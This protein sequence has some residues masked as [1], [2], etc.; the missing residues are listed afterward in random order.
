MSVGS[1]KSKRPNG[2][3]VMGS[4]ITGE[5]DAAEAGERSDSDVFCFRAN[6]ITSTHQEEPGH[7]FEDDSDVEMCLDFDPINVHIAPIQNVPFAYDEYDSVYPTHSFVLTEPEDDGLVMSETSE[8]APAIPANDDP[9]INPIVQDTASGTVDGPDWEETTADD[10]GLLLEDEAPVM[11]AAQSGWDEPAAMPFAGPRLVDADALGDAENA[12]SDGDLLAIEELSAEEVVQRLV[13]EELALEAAEREAQE[14]EAQA[15]ETQ[16]AEALALEARLAETQ[17][18]EAQASEEQAVEELAGDEQVADVAEADDL[19]E[20][21]PSALV[22]GADDLHEDATTEDPFASEDQPLEAVDI[23]DEEVQA[24][25]DLAVQP[26]PTD[27]PLKEVVVEEG[28]VVDA[29]MVA[30]AEEDVAFDEVTEAS[31]VDE[32][33]APEEP[34]PEAIAA[35]RLL[36]EHEASPELPEEEPP[37]EVYTAGEPVVDEIEGE[38]EVIPLATAAATAGALTVSATPRRRGPRV[39]VAVVLCGLGLAGAVWLGT[40]LPKIIDDMTALPP[41]AQLDVI[42]PQAG[43]AVQNAGWQS[44]TL[45]PSAEPIQGVLQGLAAVTPEVAPLP[46]PEPTLS[47]TNAFIATSEMVAAVAP[48]QDTLSIN[49]ANQSPPVLALAPAWTPPAIAVDGLAD[50]KALEK[51]QSAAISLAKLD[52][53]MPATG[54]GEDGVPVLGLAELPHD[55]AQPQALLKTASPSDAFERAGNAG[56][57]PLPDLFKVLPKARWL[58][59]LGVQLAESAN[60]KGLRV[61]GTSDVAPD[62]AQSPGVTIVAA[63]GWY[64]GSVEELEGALNTTAVNEKTGMGEVILTVSAEGQPR[65]EVIQEM[66]FARSHATPGGTTFKAEFDGR[67]WRTLVTGTGTDTDLEVGDVIVRDYGTKEKFAY[68][69]ASERVLG[70]AQTNGVEKIQFA[71]LRNDAVESAQLS[72]DGSA[73]DLQ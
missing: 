12:S 40:S 16:A 2:D 17:E 38:A 3:D 28:L 45:E 66:P 51:Q 50:T 7:L 68:A 56:P 20:V 4:L 24:P 67:R 11:E 57:M 53:V 65:R 25:D 71:I 37:T 43:D 73:L 42:S 60:P 9:A 27:E 14:A 10:Q 15:A 32:T 34:T 64:V 54:T 63:N 69:T 61:L 52:P 26:M 47:V 49:L 46:D 21:D 62:W 13:A 39:A 29:P 19:A 1:K 41:T 31:L 58:P 5:T 36:A 30:Q 59:E 48:N 18:V 44:A 55:K 6:E 8:D 22:A 35:A 72:V 70:W 23:S 33:P